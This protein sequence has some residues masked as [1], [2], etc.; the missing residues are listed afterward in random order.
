M[1]EVKYFYPFS[2]LNF[3]DLS[4]MQETMMKA[5]GK[6]NLYHLAFMAFVAWCIKI[7]T[8]VSWWRLF[9]IVCCTYGFGLLL[10]QGIIILIFI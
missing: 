10:L 5:L 7:Y 9:V 4:D 1:E 6:I 8:N 2:L 3:F